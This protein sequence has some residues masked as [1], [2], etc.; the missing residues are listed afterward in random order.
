VALSLPPEIV[1]G[2][3]ICMTV[4][5]GTSLRFS[6]RTDDK[7]MRDMRHGAASHQLE[8]AYA[9][10]LAG[11]RRISLKECYE[12]AGVLYPDLNA[13]FEDDPHDAH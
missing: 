10:I 6:L 5:L 8:T 4:K 7:A 1:G 2:E 9:A 13:G 12:L 3:P 11:P